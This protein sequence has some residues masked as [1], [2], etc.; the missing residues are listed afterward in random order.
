[1]ATTPELKHNTPARMQVSGN[2]PVQGYEIRGGWLFY[3]RARDGWELRAWAPGAW[4]V[5]EH[6]RE[7][8]MTKGRGGYWRDTEA[9]VAVMYTLCESDTDPTVVIDE[10]N[11]CDPGFPEWGPDENDYPGWWSEE[12]ATAVAEWAIGEVL[13]RPVEGEATP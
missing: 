13:R 10:S 3:F 9:E 6:A 5:P 2:C 8:L 4:P 7:I 1:M 12:Y 11:E